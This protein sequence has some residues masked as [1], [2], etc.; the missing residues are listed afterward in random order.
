MGRLHW[1]PREDRGGGGLPGSLPGASGAFQG[2]PTASQRFLRLPRASKSCAN[3]LRGKGPQGLLAQDS[4]VPVPPQRRS[5]PRAVQTLET[6]MSGGHGPSGGHIAPRRAFLGAP[7]SGGR[8]PATAQ[9]PR[10]RAAPEHPGAHRLEVV[11]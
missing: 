11:A 10:V 1:A 6:Q 8:P 4:A 5:H 9:A 7:W 3:N 2:L